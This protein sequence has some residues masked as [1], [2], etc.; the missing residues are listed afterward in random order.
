MKSIFLKII[1]FTTLLFIQNCKAQASNEYINFYS[2]IAS[3]LN[4]IVPNKTQF[5]G[6]NFS[7]FSNELLTKNI[8]II[9]IGIDSKTDTSPT[10][11]VLSLNFSDRNISLVA[12]ENEFQ[13]PRIWITFENEI[14]TPQI[15]NMLK[16]YNGEWNASFAQFFANMKIEKIVFSG[17]NG[18]N[19][20]DRSLK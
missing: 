9:R 7:N 4:T 6:Q 19:N 18:Y 2:E 1:F 8:S 15:L 13:Y 10:Y 12:S 14:P 17:I 20:T 11:H 16:Q 3:K 5:Y